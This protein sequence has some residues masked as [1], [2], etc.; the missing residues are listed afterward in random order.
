[1]TYAMALDVEVTTHQKG[2][3]FHPDNFLVTIS[4]KSELWHKYYNIYKDKNLL[5]KVQKDVDNCSLLVLFNGKFDLHWLKRVGI[6]FENKRVWDCQ[7]YEFIHSDQTIPYPSLDKTAERFG[8][9]LKPDKI[10]EY[11]D[12]GIQT[13]EIPEQELE[14]YALHDTEVTW[15]VYL[16]QKEELD[17]RKRTLL[18]LVNQD[19]LVLEEMEYNGLAFD[20]NKSLKMAEENKKRVEDIQASLGAYHN[21]PDFNWASNDHLSALL[22]GGII[23]STRRVPN[24]YYKTGKKAGEIKFKLE[25]VEYRLPRIYKPIRGSEL[26]KEG[27]FSVEEDYLRKLEGNE[28]LI[29]GILEIKKLEKDTNTYLLGLPKLQETFGWNTYIHGQFNQCVAATG[30]LSSSKP[31][32]QNLSEKSQKCFRS[33]Y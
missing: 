29:T 2:S 12:Q 11:W 26:K 9:P 16:R 22:Y 18:S 33:R 17:P 10:K 23:R 31:N 13:H 15:Q 25:T 8:L 24:G 5:D 30:R 6:N 14:E 1:M 4:T 7:N 28:A 20:K 19:L 32:L 21:V 27:Y 3:P